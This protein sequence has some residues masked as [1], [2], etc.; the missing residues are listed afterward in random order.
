MKI[1]SI[2]QIKI[3]DFLVV[4]TCHDATIYR[5]KDI[6]GFELNVEYKS[7][8]KYVSGGRLDYGCFKRPSKE[9]YAHS[10]ALLYKEGLEQ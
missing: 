3:G 4:N 5:V 2:K 9:Q 7:G 8:S 6:N 1:K 10:F